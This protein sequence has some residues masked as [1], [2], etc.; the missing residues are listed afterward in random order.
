MKRL[1][2]VDEIIGGLLQALHGL[3][4][5][6]DSRSLWLVRDTY[7]RML[8]DLY[9]LKS[10]PVTEFLLSQ[11]DLLLEH[12]F[13]PMAQ[14]ESFLT[15]MK[16]RIVCPLWRDLI[17]RV[18]HL[19]VPG[20]SFWLPDGGMH[21]IFTSHFPRLTSLLASDSSVAILDKYVKL[22]QL[23]ALTLTPGYYSPETDETLE[24]DRL[25]SLRK[26]VFDER[27]RLRV[28]GLRYLTNLTELVISDEHLSLRKLSRFT[29]L[30]SL[31]LYGFE[32]DYSLPPYP[33]YNSWEVFC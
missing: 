9:T 19:N 12:L 23:E 2:P 8:D 17:S 11:H 31:S 26:L 7:T 20:K 29:S 33:V 15:I 22:E 13:Q 1:R 4:T 28:E 18:T 10:R 27:C 32:R 21:W 16:L 25:T 30:T 5:T 6:M 3:A 14:R 24:L